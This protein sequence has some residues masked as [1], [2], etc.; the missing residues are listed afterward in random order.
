MAGDDNSAQRMVGVNDYHRALSESEIAADAH[1]EF[2][3]GLWEEIGELQFQFMV[4]QGLRPEHRLV[5]IGCGA[6]RGGLHFVRYLDR[7]HYYGL[8]LNASLI[9]AG[10]LELERASLTDRD[11]HL[12]VDDQFNLS[13]F[14]CTFDY[15]ISVSLVT[16]LFSNHI[17]RCF[18]G[19]RKVMHN[20]SRFYMT[21]FEAPSPVHLEPILHSPGDALTYFDA[22]PFHYAFAELAH[23]ARQSGLRAQL[24]GP[25]GHPRDQ[26]MVC[27]TPI[28][29]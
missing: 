13:R 22:D 27:L 25:W 28:L 14:G 16:H 20:D 7:G 2:V 15:A 12:L 8:D 17:A 3:G 6:L 29:L 18:C 11:A 23:L 10:R 24:I 4:A 21:F 26:R 1:R 19:M 5:D 9:A